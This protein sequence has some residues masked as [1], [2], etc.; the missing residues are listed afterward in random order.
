MKKKPHIVLDTDSPVECYICG[1]VI[2]PDEPKTIDGV[3]SV[4]YLRVYHP[5]CL[6]QLEKGIYT[7]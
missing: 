4:K 6:E 5:H 7:K 1:E 2:R 3:G